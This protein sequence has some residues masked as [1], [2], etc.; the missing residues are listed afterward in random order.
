MSCFYIQRESSETQ[1][2]AT[3]CLAAAV[4][5]ALE[6]PRHEYCVL[7]DVG[8]A[9]AAVREMPHAHGPGAPVVAE[10]GH[11]LVL[12]GEGGGLV[13]DQRRA[14]GRIE[15]LVHDLVGDRHPGRVARLGAADAARSEVPG[16][17]GGYIVQHEHLAALG[18]MLAGIAEGDAR[19]GLGCA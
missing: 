11:E 1:A 2:N 6:I 3:T 19:L 5:L 18:V 9:Q 8:S 14:E 7:T 17:P 13:G 10:A 16:T 15:M 12:A 4:L